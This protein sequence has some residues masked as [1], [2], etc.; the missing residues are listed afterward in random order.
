[1]S[2]SVSPPYSLSDAVDDEKEFWEHIGSLIDQAIDTALTR[3]GFDEAVDTMKSTAR[4]QRLIAEQLKE[5]AAKQISFTASVDHLTSNVTVRSADDDLLR[6]EVRKL[7]ELI[8]R[9]AQVAIT[10][11]TTVPLVKP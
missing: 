6:I 8:K 1:M 5:L 7:I 4:T 3:R 9:P 11:D 2:R 10:A